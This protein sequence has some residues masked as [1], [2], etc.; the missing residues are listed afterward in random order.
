M[1]KLAIGLWIVQLLAA[2]T[3]LIAAG[4]QTES[5]VATGPTLTVIGLLLGLT[6]RAL[7]SKSALSFALSGPLVCTFIAFLIA[8]LHWS[9]EEGHTPTLI[10]LITYV[11]LIAPLAIISCREIWQW[12]TMAKDSPA[13]AFQFRL[14]TL[15][16]AMTAACILIAAAKFLADY[17]RGERLSF[18]SF[19]LIVL[20][21]SG[22]VMWRWQG[23]Q[24]QQS[25]IHAA[26]IEKSD[27]V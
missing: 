8:A 15:F 20:V 27:T 21:L 6:T 24:L 3:M 2:L 10:V 1:K 4:V 16:I 7:Q 18:G 11:I 19:T 9:P 22:L 25:D 5:I 14:K 17:V 23:L 26:L 13:N 12:N